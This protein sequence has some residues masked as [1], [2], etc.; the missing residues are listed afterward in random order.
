MTYIAIFIEGSYF[1]VCLVEFQ[2]WVILIQNYLNYPRFWARFW[3]V[4]KLHEDLALPY[5]GGTFN[6]QYTILT[7]KQELTNVSL[8][9]K[10]N[11][12]KHFICKKK[13]WH[14][15][16]HSKSS[17]HIFITS[18]LFVKRFHSVAS[19]TLQEG[20]YFYKTTHDVFLI[21]HAWFKKMLDD[22]NLHK[23]TSHL[24]N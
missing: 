7:I 11:F 22:R 20:I 3:V 16:L 18:S 6:H 19:K 13:K 9:N 12:C 15:P 23:L 5:S 2:R 10:L 21:T 17:H 1:G 4:N 8:K 14:P 24:H